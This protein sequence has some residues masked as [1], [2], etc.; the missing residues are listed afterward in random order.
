MA[1]AMT[2]ST[3]PDTGDAIARETF[4]ESWLATPI[5]TST[6]SIA[7]VYDYVLGGK[8]NFAVDRV[9]GDA[10]LSIEGAASMPFDNRFFIKRVVRFLV[11]EA[12][13]DQIIDIGS[14]L[15]TSSNVH[16]FAR[17]ANP[18]A[19][20][21]YVDNDPIVLAHGRAL[22]DDSGATTVITAD[23][24]EPEGIFTNPD[25]LRLID[26]ERPVG[27]LI[28]SVLHHL[29]DH[30]NPV[31]VAAAIRDRVPSGSYLAI[32]NFHDSGDPRAREIEKALLDKGLGTGRFRT[33]PDQRRYF[34]GLELVD[35]GLVPVNEWR[36]DDETPADSPVHH[37]YIGGV[38]RKP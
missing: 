25:T 3:A 5:D 14:G 23:L 29:H 13:I 10:F 19:R 26:F 28:A 12:G 38:G 35:P 6:A 7:R 31:A 37:L 27:V 1:A 24:L 18:G 33:W 34:H 16:E 21:V 4:D 15:P 32:A 36:P 17:E 22:L 20:V 11:A 2:D 30:Q 9:P 8:D